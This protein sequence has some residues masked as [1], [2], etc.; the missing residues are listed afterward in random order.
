MIRQ[1][2]LERNGFSEQMFRNLNTE[3]DWQ[4]A[5]EA[6]VVRPF[7]EKLGLDSCYLARTNG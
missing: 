4:E 6:G 1:D 5:L 7:N 3:S 2:E